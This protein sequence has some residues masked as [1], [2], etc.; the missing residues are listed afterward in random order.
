MASVDWQALLENVTNDRIVAFFTSPYGL[1]ALGAFVLLSLAMKWRVMFVV[2]AASLA[3]SFV[4]RYSLAGHEE[5]PSRHL[6]L[7]AGGAVAVGAFVVYFL[8][9]RDD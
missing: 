8:F 3:I 1:A 7:F 5:G 4:T 6:F 9:I 2:I